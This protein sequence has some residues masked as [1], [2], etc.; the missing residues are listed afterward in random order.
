M[1]PRL[2]ELLDYIDAERRHVLQVASALPPERWASRPAEDRWSISEVCWHLAKVE[3]GVAKLIGKLAGAARVAG[4]PAE[5]DHRS[6]LDSLDGRGIVDRSRP[7]PAPSQITP[8][9]A[10]EADTVQQQLRESRELMRAA[11][12]EAD[13][14]AL[15][16]ITRDHPVL[17]EINLYQWILFV[18]Q[19]ER[20]HAEQITEIASALAAS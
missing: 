2:T 10:P 4:H 16:S 6:V 3:R 8:T 5:T 7:I 18:G 17:G 14:L 1:Q 13:G 19:H 9:E 20:R 15:A 12:A 11:I